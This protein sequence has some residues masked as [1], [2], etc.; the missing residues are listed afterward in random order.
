MYHGI[1]CHYYLAMYRTYVVQ[2]RATRSWHFPQL[3]NGLA[4]GLTSQRHCSYEILT[5]FPTHP[6][7]LVSEVS[8]ILA[9]TMLWG[10]H[11]PSKVWNEIT[12]PFQNFNS[13]AWEWI[14][15]FIPHFTEHVITYP[16]YGLS[17]TMLVKGVPGMYSLTQDDTFCHCYIATNLVQLEDARFWQ[18]FPLIHSA[19]LGG[20]ALSKLN[21]KLNNDLAAGSALQ[22]Y[23]WIEC[24]IE[25]WIAAYS[26]W[27]LSQPH[28][29]WRPAF[30]CPF[31]EINKLHWNE[32][33]CKWT[34]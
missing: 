23:C 4:A 28:V 2:S 29:E 30:H 31:Q 34:S 7:C 13:G 8:S 9:I 27:T 25:C 24:W 26:V 15:H 22:G 19:L 10:I 5:G 32:L 6:F 20:G 17:S 12:C 11:I 18:D 3:N 21:I 1:F 14:C 16:W 33:H